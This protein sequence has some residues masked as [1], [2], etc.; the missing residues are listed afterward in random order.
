MER[1]IMMKDMPLF[2]GLAVGFSIAIP[3]GPM[4]LLCI[5][6]TLACGMRAGLCTGLGAATVNVLYG[7]VVILGLDTIAPW[8]ESNGKVMSIIAGILLLWAAARTLMRRNTSSQPL[9]DAGQ[10]PLGAYLSAIV[11]NAAN[12]MSLILIVALLSPVAGRAAASPG[13]MAALLL[14]MFTAAVT[15]WFCLSGSIALL[16]SRLRPEMLLYV[17]QVAG[18]LLTIYG[19]LALT[20]Y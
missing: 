17:N 10:S 2:V 13:G 12:P 20:R 16:R 11:I 1:K 8:I 18:M 6:R 14:G 15:W 4:G 19:T 5:Q 9:R 7:A 3:I